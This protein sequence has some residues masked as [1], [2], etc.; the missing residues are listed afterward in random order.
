MQLFKPHAN[1][2]LSG[3]QMGGQVDAITQCSPFRLLVSPFIAFDPRYNHATSAISNHQ[4][5]VVPLDDFR[6]THL[7]PY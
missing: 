3:M 6:S 4:L 7:V 5:F 1:N 2:L